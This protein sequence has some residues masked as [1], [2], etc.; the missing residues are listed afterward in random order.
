MTG[1]AQAIRYADR[2]RLDGR[3]FIVLGAGDGIGAETARALSQSG[4]IPFCVDLVQEKADAIA[5]AT[6]GHACVADV[7][8]ADGVD[9]VFAEAKRVLGE[10]RGVV[11]IVGA[12][13]VKPIADF[14]DDEFEWQQAIVLRHALYTVRAAARTMSADGVLTFVGS[15]IGN[16]AVPNQIVY[17]TYKAALHHLVRGAA[18]ELGRQGIRVNAVAPGV[19]KTPLLLDLLD[20]EQWRKLDEGVPTGAVAR[21]DEI[22]SALLFLSTDLASHVNGVV[23]PVDGGMGVVAALPTLNFGPAARDD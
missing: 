14:S 15:M 16:L 12:V 2:L 1:G 20:K 8:S 23:L 21:M 19:I 3:G 18:A 10:I 22:A 6:G 7:T 4:A 5:S 9:H 11:D 13:R 17:G